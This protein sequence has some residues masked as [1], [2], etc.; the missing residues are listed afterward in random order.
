MNGGAISDLE[1]EGI[2]AE[3][4]SVIDAENS[5]DLSEEEQAYERQRD[6]DD[7]ITFPSRNTD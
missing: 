4:Q 5:Y 3:E 7:G 1:D 6:K 2:S